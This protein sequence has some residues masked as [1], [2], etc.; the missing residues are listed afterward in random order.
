MLEN[1]FERLKSIDEE[2]KCGKKIQFSD[3]GDRMALKGIITS[4]AMSWFIQT[5]GNYLIINYASLIFAKSGNS[6]DP[7]I[8]SITLAIIQIVAGLISTQM[9]DTFGRKTILT[10]SLAGSA[11]G[12]FALST[13]SYLRENGYNVSM[14][15]WLPLT[16]L[17]LIIFISNVG[18]IALAH[19]VAIENYPTKIRT[20]GVIFYSLCVSTVAF[21]AD[22]YFP[23][24]LE[25]IQLHGCLLFFA[26]SC[27]CGTIF[28]AFMNE[29]KG[30]SLDAN[31]MQGS[32]LPPTPLSAIRTGNEKVI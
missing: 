19:I 32:K 9:G 18:I 7:N 25:S 10:I 14:Y 15:G 28:V 27:C 24:A 22:K 8:S 21:T 13:F 1:E 5:T 31:E 2:K 12:L 3:F 29:T 11:F 16:S 30:Q 6:L 20:V 17:S 4:I 23:I 26:I